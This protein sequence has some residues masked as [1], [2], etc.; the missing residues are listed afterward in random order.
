MDLR[1]NIL[2]AEQSEAQKDPVHQMLLQQLGP[3]EAAVEALTTEKDECENA[4]A[5]GTQSMW[6]EAERSKTETG[7]LTDNIYILEAY[8]SNLADGDKEIMEAMRRDA[9]GA[10]YVDSGGLEELEGL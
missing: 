2:K 9:Y 7:I 1:L 8:L 5:G 3:L 10:L 4:V 6:E